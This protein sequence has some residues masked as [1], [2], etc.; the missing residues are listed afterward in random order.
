MHHFLIPNIIAFSFASCFDISIPFDFFCIFDCRVE[1][2]AGSLL[3]EGEASVPSSFTLVT[4]RGIFL[5]MLY[6]CC[7]LISRRIFLPWPL[8]VD[9]LL[10]FARLRHGSDVV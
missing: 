3:V 7:G 4:A 5:A 1:S 2:V 9:I 6:L 8:I 10:E